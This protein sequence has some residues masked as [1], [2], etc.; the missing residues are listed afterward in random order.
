MAE[1]V[2]RI[3][4]PAAIVSASICFV[5]LVAVRDKRLIFPMTI[6]WLL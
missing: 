1:L 4:V 5:F 2:G 6:A 3:Y